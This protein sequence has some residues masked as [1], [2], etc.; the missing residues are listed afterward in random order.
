[1]SKT[2]ILY[3]VY[4]SNERT[5]FKLASK[6]YLN[7]WRLVGLRAKTEGADANLQFLVGMN[8]IIKNVVLQSDNM[9]IDQLRNAHEWLAF[10][11]LRQSNN[12]NTSLG[13]ELSGTDYGFKLSHLNSDNIPIINFINTAHNVKADQNS[14]DADG[15]L[16][17]KRCLKF[18]Q[19]SVV[20][21]TDRMP[22]LSLVIEWMPYNKALFRGTGAGITGMTI[23]E[24]NLIVDEILDETPSPDGQLIYTS[25]E[26]DR[27]IVPAVADGDESDEKYKINGFND[28]FVGRV[29]VLNQ[30]NVTDT[31]DTDSSSCQD[32]EVI[33]VRL[34]GRTQFSHPIDSANKKMDMCAKSWGH[35]NV[36]QGCQYAYLTEADNFLKDSE[37]ND[38]R[39]FC[40]YGGWAVNERVSDLEIEYKRDGSNTVRDNQG[41]NPF[42]FDVFCEVKKVL[43]YNKAGVNVAYA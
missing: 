23:Q 3:P 4:H 9:V 8:A 22:N 16:N 7:D 36:P 14:T 18:L 21:P 11:Q 1:M 33:Q 27:V 30:S 29:M 40:S 35:L 13:N 10:E 41:L 12:R 42:N 43:T 28:K 34:N 19:S 17:L 38:I 15:W 37:V 25:V 5:V 6:K 20:L 39:G 2:N 26:Q 24:P 31:S 32:E